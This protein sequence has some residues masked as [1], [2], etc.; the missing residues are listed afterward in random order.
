[1]AKMQTI[2]GKTVKVLMRD[3]LGRVVVTR[4]KMRNAYVTIP[5]GTRME[6]TG[7]W[8]SGVSLQGERCEHCGVRPRIMKVPRDQVLLEDTP[9]EDR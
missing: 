2:S 4:V 3:L 1:M 6:V 9:K 7:F 8:R 5:A